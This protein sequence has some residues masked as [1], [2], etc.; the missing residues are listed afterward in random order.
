MYR[1][2]IVDDEIRIREVIR[3]YGNLYEYQVFEADEGSKAIEMVQE[4]D[5]DC[6][7]LDIMMPNLDGYTTCRRIKEIKNIPIIMLS[8]RNQEDDKLYGFE[9]GIDDYVSK[10]FSPK[11]LM[12]RVKVVIE[13]NSPRKPGL[14]AIDGIRIDEE[15]HE[16]TIDGQKAHLTNKE[17]ELLLYLVNNINKAVSRDTLLERIW[18]FDSNSGDRTVDTHIKMLRHH[19][20]DYGKRIVTVRGVGYK[21]EKD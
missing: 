12:A 13:R 14:T 7:I 16:V 19:L 9:L 17:Y 6:I 4:N 11:E 3:E 8:A 2:L 21:L 20:G 5:F 18:G 15:A 1:I 10:P